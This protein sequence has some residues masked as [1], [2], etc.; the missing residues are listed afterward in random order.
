MLFRSLAKYNLNNRYYDF[1]CGWGVR[2]LS[3]L[4]NRV[5]YFGTDPNYELVARLKQI[6]Q[7]YD[8]VNSTIS[9]V[10]I[11]A[12][13][14]E[15]FHPDWENT[16]GVAFSSPPYF[17]LEDYRIGAQ[18]IRGRDYQGW[19]DEYL[20]PTIDNIKRYLVPGGHIIVN[21][22]GRAHV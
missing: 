14:S 18:S 1:S 19:L 3:A 15:V 20:Q 8:L 7:D 11:R 5:A 2:L 16:M 21:K 10:D 13:G 12:T 22:I 9:S 6:H 17:D 4:K